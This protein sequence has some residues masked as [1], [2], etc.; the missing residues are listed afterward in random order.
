MILK[1]VIIEGV[2]LLL[3]RWMKI[4]IINLRN[5]HGHPITDIFLFLKMI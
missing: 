2:G 4:C 5:V 3:L 1:L